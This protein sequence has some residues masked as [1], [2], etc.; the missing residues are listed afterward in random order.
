MKGNELKRR[1]IEFFKKKGHKEIR[2]SSLIPE[3]D[4]TVLFTTAGM[5]P[6]VP[7]LLGQKHPLGKRLVNIQRCIRTGDIDDVGDDVHLT[8][9][10]MLGN[11]SLGDY[12]KKEAIEMSFEFLTK[13]LNIPIE[14]LAITCFVGDKNADKDEESAEVWKKLGISSKRIIFLGKEDNWWGPAGTTGPCGPDTEMFYWAGDEKA[15]EQFNPGDSRWVEIW[16]DVFMQ[17]NKLQNGKL[18]SLKQKNVDTGMGVERTAMLLQGKKNVFETDLFLPILKTIRHLSRKDDIKAERIIADHI[19]T[20]VFI[21]NE[22]IVPSNLGHGYVLRRLIRR[23]SRYARLIDLDKDG[24]NE[25]AKKVIEIYRETYDGL[26]KK[27]L[28]ILDELKKENE[29]FEKTLTSGLRIFEKEISKLDGKELSGKIAFVLFTSYGFPLEMTIE[30]AE[31]KGFRVEEETFWEEYKR[32]Q[33]LSRQATKGVFKSGLADN[34]EEVTQ[35]HTVTHLL[36]QALKNNL[37]HDIEQRGS[38]ITKERIRFDFNFDRKLTDEEKKKIEDEVNEKI[39][40]HLDV[41]S[42]EMSLGD[43]RKSGASGIFEERYGNVV[44]VY[45]IGRYSKEICTG[46]HVENTKNIKGKFRIVKEESSS[47]GIRRIKG[48]LEK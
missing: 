42:E 32:H 6:L 9:F 36:L 13:E 39:N 12:F 38:N 27:E 37:S 30:L 20:S 17:Y 1:Y 34:S 23:A 5:H 22:K 33:D 29:K 44:S 2:N 11:W 8:F 19:K 35:Y 46:P 26:K 21:L 24:L 40:A 7:Y 15:P 3:N 4:P 47:A 43:A 48:I 14:K 41:K 25:V 31:E 18:E 10:E 16:N 28:F 45:T